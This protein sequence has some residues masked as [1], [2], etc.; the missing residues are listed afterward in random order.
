MSQQND[1]ER[2]LSKLT[3]EDRHAME[4]YMAFDPIT[5]SRPVVSKKH[6]A[7]LRKKAKKFGRTLQTTLER[8]IEKYDEPSEAQRKDN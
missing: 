2:Q 7:I 4:G 8:A 1:I 6:H 3:P 5:Q